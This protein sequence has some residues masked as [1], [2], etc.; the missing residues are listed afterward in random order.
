[1]KQSKTPRR[2]VLHDATAATVREEGDG[3]YVV[4]VI[5]TV[6]GAILR[7]AAYNVK[8]VSADVALRFALWR[9]RQRHVD[10]SNPWLHGGAS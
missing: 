1:M 6:N 10:A 9:F 8:A 7:S 2:P 3:R 4:M 5:E